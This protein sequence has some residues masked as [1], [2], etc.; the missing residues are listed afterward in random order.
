M[1]QCVSSSFKWT[2]MDCK[3]YFTLVTLFLHVA[4]CAG[5]PVW[6]DADAVYT[7]LYTHSC[8]NLKKVTNFN[9]AILTY[10][11]NYVIM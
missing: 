1:D 6:T 5:A 3:F 10:I 7:R 4:V 11:C 9:E 8:K 2:H